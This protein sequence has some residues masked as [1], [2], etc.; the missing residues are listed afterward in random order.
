MPTPTPSAPSRA[1]LPP[2]IRPVALVTGASSGI[3][4]AVADRFAADGRC[5]LLLAG[6]DEPR[7]AA[8]AGRTGGVPLPGDLGEPAGV[9]KLAADALDREGRVDVLVAAAGLGWAG[10]LGAMP[11]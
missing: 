5:R 3:G 2:P 8:V 4:A 10:P 1:A 9:A 7:L 11:A 6:R